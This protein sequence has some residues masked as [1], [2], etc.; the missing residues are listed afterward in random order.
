[1]DDLMSEDEIDKISSEILD[2]LSRRI[3][4]WQLC[5][6]RYLT[7]IDMQQKCRVDEIQRRLIEVGKVAAKAGRNPGGDISE[8]DKIQMELDRKR[9]EEGWKALLVLVKALRTK[10][11]PAASESSIRWF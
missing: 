9:M 3:P 2:E 4:T 7:L 11:G 8:M 10:E 5:A 6:I 1:M